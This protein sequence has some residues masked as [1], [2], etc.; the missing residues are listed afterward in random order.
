MVTEVAR[1]TSQM[2]NL[3]ALILLLGL[4]LT[5]GANAA[6][7][8][9]NDG[10]RVDPIQ[11]VLGGDLAY[12]GPNLEPN[13]DLTHANLTY[14]DLTNADLTGANLISA[15]L[16]SVYL[17]GANLISASLN[18]VDLTDAILTNADLSNANLTGAD[19]SGADLPHANLE[20]AILSGAIL[21]EVSSGG[22]T[23]VPMALP[24]GWTLV[25]GYL[26]GPEA[27]LVSADLR[28]AILSFAD[29]TDANLY[30]ADLRYAILSYA[31][32]SFADLTDAIL[33]NADLSNATYLGY[34][35]GSALYNAETDFTNARDGGAGST[36]FDPVAKGW[37]FVPEPSPHLAMATALLTLLTLAGLRRR[38]HHPTPI[39]PKP[40]CIGA[41][42]EHPLDGPRN[43]RA[44]LTKTAET[45]NNLGDASLAP[46]LRPVQDCLG[47][48]RCGDPASHKRGPRGVVFANGWGRS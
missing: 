13:A 28:Y 26:I 41:R 24:T 19:L 48:C 38:T 27:F 11:S 25:G 30:D 15:S 39:A 31:I 44:D 34:T 3:I 22:I 2:R 35:V 20:H 7:Y 40:P 23:G 1:Y 4:L 29:L 42:L 18:S 8:L 9:K 10:V 37:T 45:R 14:A 46:P 33:T 5:S 16:N 12:A 36:L 47:L 6:S 43:I 17:T 32:L 21:S